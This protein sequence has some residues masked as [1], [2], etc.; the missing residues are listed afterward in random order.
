MQGRNSAAC[1]TS[2]PVFSI[3]TDYRIES[4]FALL[5]IAHT[6]GVSQQPTPQSPS[7]MVE[8]TRP[9]PRITQIEVSGQRIELKTL[10][11]ARLFIGPHV[12]PN[13]PVP[14]LIHFHGGPWLIERH[15]ALKLPKAALI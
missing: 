2:Q 11:G 5:V 8:H 13:K 10:K 9:H 15:V 7:P 1:Y 4:V 14:L 3:R 12:N 6:S